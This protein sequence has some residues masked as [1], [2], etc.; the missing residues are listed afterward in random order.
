MAP[1]FSQGDIPTWK[2]SS[3]MREV[4]LRSSSTPGSAASTSSRAEGRR[5]CRAGQADRHQPVR[6]ERRHQEA[7]RDGTLAG[8]L[9]GPA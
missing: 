7:P 5:T 2:N 4:V 3:A 1:H 8:A 9:A 6:G